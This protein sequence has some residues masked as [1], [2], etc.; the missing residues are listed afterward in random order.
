MQFVLEFAAIR[1]LYMVIIIYGPPGSGKGTQA[2]ILADYF[3]LFHF[4]TGRVLEQTVHDTALQ[5]DSVIK[6]EREFFDNGILCTPEWVSDIVEGKIKELS[7]KGKGLVFSGSP[8]TLSEAEK[9]LP[10]LIGLYKK[11]KIYVIRLLVNPETSIFRNSNRKICKDCGW[12]LIFSKEGA[13]LNNCEHCGGELAARGKLDAPETIQVRLQEYKERTAPV[14][15]F[16]EEK[17]IKVIDI[18][19]EPMPDLVTNDILKNLPT[20]NN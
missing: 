6:R 13:N 7:A 20:A 8:R 18:D 16:L 15:K 14:Y 2:Q 12:P 5:N 10:L 11:E 9:I 4:D 17:G 3:G 1:G 19:G